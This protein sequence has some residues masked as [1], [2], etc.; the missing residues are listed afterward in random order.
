M[1]AASRKKKACS[2]RF[3]RSVTPN[4]AAALAKVNVPQTVV[5]G[6][7]AGGEGNLLNLALLKYMG[8]LKDAKLT[9]REYD[10]LAPPAPSD[11]AALAQ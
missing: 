3:K 11:Q 7:T 1:A 9:N 5:G 6:G 2:P 8:V 4:V 10:R